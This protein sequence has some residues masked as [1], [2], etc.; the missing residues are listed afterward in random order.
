MDNSAFISYRRKNSWSLA[1]AIF[2]ELRHHH[3]DVFMDV[4]SIGSGQFDLI[5]L[6]QIAA[7]PYFLLLL[8]PE[9]L[10][11]CVNVGDWVLREISEALRLERIIIPLHS[12]EFDFSEIDQFLPKPIAQELKR[13][14]AIE[15]HQRYFDASIAEIHKFLKPVNI[16]IVPTPQSEQNKV[17]QIQQEIVQQKTQPSPVLVSRAVKA[18]VNATLGSVNSLESFVDVVLMTLSEKEKSS[19]DVTLFFFQIIERTPEFMKIYQKLGGLDRPQS[20]NPQI[21]KMIKK[22]LGKEL[23]A[24]VSISPDDC[25]LISSYTRFK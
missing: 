13:F 24:Q 18:V 15:I 12:T 14:N 9:S 25:T 22:I 5:I 16:A 20:V 19:P 17:Q 23:L 11:R 1:R 4:D 2:M 21:G 3:H 10:D 7:R 6:N 8:T